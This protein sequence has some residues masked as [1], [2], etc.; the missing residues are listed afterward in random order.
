MATASSQ[1]PCSQGFPP[2][3]CP[4]RRQRGPPA[5]G[6]LEGL[7]VEQGGGQTQLVSRM[8]SKGEN[9]KGTK[10]CQQM[11]L[12]YLTDSGGSGVVTWAGDKAP[13]PPRQKA[14]PN[15]SLENHSIEESKTR[16][17]RMGDGRS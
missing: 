16:G 15:L 17:F 9:G 2:G 12:C 3:C 4:G 14:S 8:F 10:C 5:P 11:L 7:E 6:G 1:G 13:P